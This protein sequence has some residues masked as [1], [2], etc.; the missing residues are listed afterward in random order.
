MHLVSNISLV[1]FLILSLAALIISI[2]QRRRAGKVRFSGLGKENTL[3]LVLIYVLGGIYLITSEGWLKYVIFLLSFVVYYL[4]SQFYVGENGVKFGIHFI[5]YDK[6]TGFRPYDGSNDV[7]LY[8]EGKS[9]G[10]YLKPKIEYRSSMIQSV[11]EM[12]GVS[13]QQR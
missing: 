4:V 13:E 2:Q 12:N 6:V 10:I 7:T 5:P 8:I 1:L 9:K 3:L 11:L